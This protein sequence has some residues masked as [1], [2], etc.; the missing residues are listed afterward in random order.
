VSFK[1]NWNWKKNKYGAQSAFCRN[2][3]YHRSKGE[4]GRCDIL[5][6]MQHGQAISEL[7]N[8]PTVKLG[9]TQKYRPD[10]TY[11]EDGKLIVEDFKGV[12]QDRFKMIKRLWPELG[13]GILRVTHFSR[14]QYVTTQEIEGKKNAER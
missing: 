11:I 6:L 10:W 1:M 13:E 9:I 5:H 7:K 8:Q 12:E 4:A 2:A 3:H 14:G